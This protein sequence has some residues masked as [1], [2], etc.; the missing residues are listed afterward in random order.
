MTHDG[1]D[2]GRVSEEIRQNSLAL[3]GMTTNLIQHRFDDDRERNLA[4]AHFSEALFLGTLAQM[5]EDFGPDATRRR[6][7][8]LLEKAAGYMTRDGRRVSIS[9]DWREG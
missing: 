3:A 6:L 8:M 4:S 1:G 2:L 9:M 7:Q 5:L